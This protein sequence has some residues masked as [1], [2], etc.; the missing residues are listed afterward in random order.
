MHT[1][2][3]NC[4]TAFNVPLA[5]HGRS[6]RA[7]QRA[8]P[9]AARPSDRSSDEFTELQMQAVPDVEQQSHT[10]PT[11]SEGVQQDVQQV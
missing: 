2:D 5:R 9:V 6:V 3:V 8:Y 11:T 4:L 7:Y 10:V 1:F